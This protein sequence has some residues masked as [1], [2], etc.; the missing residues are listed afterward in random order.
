MAQGM[1]H[2]HAIFLCMQASP[3]SQRA[4]WLKTLHEWHWISSAVCMIGILLFS[5][6]GITLNHSSQIEA[7]PVVAA[8]KARLPA[9][10]LAAT[11][12]EPDD[13]RMAEGLQGRAIHRVPG[14]ACPWSYGAG[15]QDVQVRQVYV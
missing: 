12:H 8:Q 13:A 3:S 4:Y 7:R 9:D 6:T 10:L 11:A 15:I 5:I 2:A 14:T 1:V